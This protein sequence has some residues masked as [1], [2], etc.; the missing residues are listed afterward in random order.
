M[1][2]VCVLLST[3]NGEKYLREQIES[4]L[5]QEGCAVNLL[6]RDDCSTDSTK[7][8]LEDYRVNGRLIWYTGDNLGAKSSFLDLVKR[9][10]D[11]DFYAF[12]DQDDIWQKD[13]LKCALDML[14]IEDSTI[15]LVYHSAYQMVD[16]NL[17]PIS[18]GGND[19]VSDTLYKAIVS[20]NSTGCTVVF[21]KRMR[22]I[23]NMHEIE[24]SLMHDNYIVK[25]CLACGGKIIHD[26]IPHILYRQ[27]DENVIGGNASIV[28]KFKR[29]IKSIF[30][31]PRYRSNSLKAINDAYFLMFSPEV[32]T[33]FSEIIY[34]RKGTNRFNLAFNSNYRTGDKRIDL[35]FIISVLLGVF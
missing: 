1:Y 10:L 25:L 17:N 34:Y 8:I 24:Q 22:D 11:V 5:N 16:S 13:K 15:P 32:K 6:V 14:S 30:S 12:C 2:T 33:I 28:N 9:S 18:I 26:N 23:L 29:Y 20:S 19:Y 35:I 4:V 27:H 31:N 21:N 7:V 3:F